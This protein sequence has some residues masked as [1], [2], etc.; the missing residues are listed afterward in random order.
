[1]IFDYD[2]NGDHLCDGGVS[3]ADWLNNHHVKLHLHLP[4][5]D[6]DDDDDNDNADAD[7][8]DDDDDDNKHLK[9][10]LRPAFL[11]TNIFALV[12]LQ[13]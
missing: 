3:K 11:E 2:D 9:M 10:D 6:D 7:N 13:D 5:H 1:M 4:T 12:T 8:A